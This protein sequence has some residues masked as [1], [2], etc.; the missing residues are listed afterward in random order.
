MSW[1][2]LLT[3]LCSIYCLNNPLHPL[4]VLSLSLS[5]TSQAPVYEFIATVAGGSKV[6]H[7]GDKGPATRASFGSLWDVFVAKNGDIYVCD[8]ASH[9][10]RKISASNR[11]ITTVA[12]I[13]NSAGYS[14]DGVQ[15]TKT[16]LNQPRGIFVD[17]LNNL[18]IADSE[19]H[20]IRMVNQDGVISTI[21]GTGVNGRASDGQLATDTPLSSPLKVIMNKNGELLIVDTF[22]YRILKVGAD[23][24]VVTVAGDGTIQDNIAPGKIATRVSVYPHFIAV[25]DAGEVF[26]ESRDSIYKV[27]TDGVLVKVVSLQDVNPTSGKTDLNAMALGS[28][29]QLYFSLASEFKIWSVDTTTGTIR[30]VVGTGVFGNS[31]DGKLAIDAKIGTQGG[32]SVA[33]NGDLYFGSTVQLRKVY[34]SSTPIPNSATRSVAPFSVLALL[35]MTSLFLVL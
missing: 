6:G 2:V 27:T 9:V 18:F 26:F 7:S 34:S 29:G 4:S 23:Q 10:V 21:V 28:D 17:E 25:N 31:G 19:N 15:A 12:G 16:K 33:S 22:S 35:M 3:L 20:R 24:R 32:M 30:H 1:L 5:S 14:G 13:A 11:V 8:V